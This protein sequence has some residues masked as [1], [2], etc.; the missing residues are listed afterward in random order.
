M[1]FLEGLV[2]PRVRRTCLKCGT[3]WTVLRS[4]TQRHL[5]GGSTAPLSGMLGPRGAQR[6]IE[7]DLIGNAGDQGPNSAAASAETRIGDALCPKCG[8]NTWTQKRAWSSSS[9]AEL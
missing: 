6:M 4:E 9:R 5:S 3:S 2:H 8:S 1:G 7:P